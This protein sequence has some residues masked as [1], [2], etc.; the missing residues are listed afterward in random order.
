M[1][2]PC[3]PRNHVFT[4][5]RKENKDV[6]V[7]PK[8]LR[9]HNPHCRWVYKFP[10]TAFERGLL[11]QV[12][13]VA[14]NTCCQEPYVT[15]FCPSSN[16][17]RQKADDVLQ[18]LLTLIQAHP[19]RQ[20]ELVRRM[21]SVQRHRDRLERHGSIGCLAKYREYQAKLSEARA[22]LHQRAQFAKLHD[23]VL[24]TDFPRHLQLARYQHLHEVLKPST[25]GIVV[26]SMFQGLPDEDDDD[27]TATANDNEYEDPD[28]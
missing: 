25:H 8:F 23:A 1:T 14:N 10:A 11:H 22:L 28:D 17:V 18:E 12:W 19:E 21:A 20:P 26:S 3:Y 4:Y 27:D 13:N 15:Y 9:C 7:S 6:R 24:E 16:E 2:T 5:K